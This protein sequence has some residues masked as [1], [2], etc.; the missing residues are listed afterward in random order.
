MLG[1]RGG[2]EATM[3]IELDIFSGRPNPHWDLTAQEAAEFTRLLADLEARDDVLAPPDGLGYRG[4]RVLQG[5][6]RLEVSVWRENVIGLGA[7]FFRAWDESRSVERFLLSTGQPH[8]DPSLFQTV[9][10]LIAAS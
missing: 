7:R 4:F 10:A 1:R 6:P 9:T 2:E 3:R 8:L 5:S